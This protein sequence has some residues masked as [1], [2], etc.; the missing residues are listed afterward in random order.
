MV[1]ATCAVPTPA[2]TVMCLIDGFETSS[3]YIRVVMGEPAVL[4][5]LFLVLPE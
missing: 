2:R 1:G 3:I 4:R 5:Q